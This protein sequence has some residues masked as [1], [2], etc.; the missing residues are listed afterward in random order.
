MPSGCSPETFTW[1]SLFWWGGRWPLP[2]RS[3]TLPPQPPSYRRHQG[4]HSS[5]NRLQC[6][7]IQ[8]TATPLEESDPEWAA[9]LYRSIQRSQ[10]VFFFS[11]AGN[12]NKRALRAS[13]VGPSQTDGAA[14]GKPPAEAA[15]L[16]RWIIFSFQITDHYRTDHYRSDI[17]FCLRPDSSL[18]L[19]QIKSLQ[20]RQLISQ[21][22]TLWFLLYFSTVSPFSCLYLKLR[23]SFIFNG[24]HSNQNA[25]RARS[26]SLTSAVIAL[27]LASMFTSR[28][29]GVVIQFSCL[30]H[31]LKNRR[32]QNPSPQICTSTCDPRGP[33]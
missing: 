23:S 4:V 27:V 29:R 16:V 8:K 14:F 9:H 12:E 25:L 7:H 1:S 22:K 17:S 20:L 3:V 10:L 28:A 11:Y 2:L 24:K 30:T 6:V 15:R 32:G 26:A 18:D 31:T 21:Q 19:F 5:S 33:P 13:R